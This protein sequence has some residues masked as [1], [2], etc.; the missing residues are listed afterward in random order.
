[1]DFPIFFKLGL[2]A[3]PK[4]AFG[5]TAAPN[6]GAF[7]VPAYAII[8]P[9]FYSFAAPVVV[10][11][12]YLQA[13]PIAP[14]AIAPVAVIPVAIAVTGLGVVTPVAPVTVF[15][16]IAAAGVIPVVFIPVATTPAPP[17]MPVTFIIAP[18]VK[19][20]GAVMLV[21]VMPV[22]TLWVVTLAV[23]LGAVTPVTDNPVVTLGILTEVVAKLFMPVG[24]S[25][26]VCF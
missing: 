13:S 21:A 19:V 23:L 15:G 18:P 5:V 9:S 16:L 2:V 6:D 25:T 26:L 8:I 11:G 7:F 24:L 4:T 12:L 20:L 22:V 10:V 17:A 3:L 14:L 1:M